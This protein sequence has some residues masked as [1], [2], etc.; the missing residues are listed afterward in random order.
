MYKYASAERFDTRRL[1]RRRDPARVRYFGSGGAIGQAVA[2]SPVGQLIANPGEA[3][4]SSPIAQFITNPGE[5]VAGIPAAVGQATGI[6]NLAQGLQGLFGGDQ[7]GAQ[8]LV[9]QAANFV[10]PPAPAMGMPG[11]LVGPPSPFQPPGFGQGLLQGFT[12]NFNSPSG[13]ADV[14]NPA[15]QLGGG[16]GELLALLDKMRQQSGGMAP[17]GPLPGGGQPSGIRILPGTTAQA[18]QG[19][20]IH[21]LIGAFTYGIL[22]GGIPSSQQA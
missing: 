8:P 4:A 5:A 22:G 2:S 20:L 6:S 9:P 1:H 10:G 13:G 18:P 16:V 21:N 19:G 14:V 7:A 11:G 17:M 3:V 15:G 12:G